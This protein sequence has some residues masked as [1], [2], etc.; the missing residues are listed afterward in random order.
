MTKT[1]S[2]NR[3][4][5]ALGV[6][7]PSEFVKAIGLQEKNQVEMTMLNN[8]IIIRRTPET[9]SLEDLINNCLEW[10][11]KPPDKYDW[12]ESCGREIL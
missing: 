4:G 2:I 8:E 10:D 1:M 7:F 9:L 6:R 5:D 12:G 11:G 3:W